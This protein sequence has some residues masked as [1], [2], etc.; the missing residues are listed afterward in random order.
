MHIEVR[1]IPLLDVVVVVV[2]VLPHTH[3]NPPPVK[4][5]LIYR[6]LC[7]KQKKNKMKTGKVGFDLPLF[8]CETEEEQN[9]NR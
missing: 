4:L 5:V 3:P 6:F 1:C 8:V 9:E 7:V 2:V